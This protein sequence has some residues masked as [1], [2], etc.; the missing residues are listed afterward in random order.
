MN[1]LS[2]NFYFDENEMLIIPFI[3]DNGHFRCNLICTGIFILH[4]TVKF[5]IKHGLKYH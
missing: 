3:N 4:Q 5:N 2:I 1:R